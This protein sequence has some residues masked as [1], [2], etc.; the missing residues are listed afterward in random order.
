MAAIALKKWG[1]EIGRKYDEYVLEFNLRHRKE[2][3]RNEVRHRIVTNLRR[4][5][6]RKLAPK[7]FSARRIPWR[8]LEPGRNSFKIIIEHFDGLNTPARKEEYDKHR[9]ELVHAL[10]PSAIY[11]GTDEFEWYIVFLFQSAELAVLECPI[12]GNAIYLI[13][14]D[15]KDLSKLSKTALLEEYSGQVAR[16]IHTGD[17]YDKLKRQLRAHGWRHSNGGSGFGKSTSAKEAEPCIEGQEASA[18]EGW[19]W[20]Y[21]PDKK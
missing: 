3:E 18:P 8:F 13:A 15:W 16:I 12:K 9:L 2:N 5:L 6:E 21:R 1:L 20:S 17:W 4:D 7:L 10:G 14:G 11:I 19:L